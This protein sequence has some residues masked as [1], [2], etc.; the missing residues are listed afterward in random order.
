MEMEDALIES[1]K[2][3]ATDLGLVIEF[4]FY[5]RNEQEE[6]V[7]FGFLVKSFGSSSGTIVI[8]IDQDIRDKTI[9]DS[10]FFI[11]ALGAGYLKYDRHL[12]IETL[13]DWRY[14][15]K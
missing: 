4:P 5:L 10:D 2:E 7:E 13:N 11:S 8:T 14:F 9:L 6:M 15:G 3:A 1:W 12:F